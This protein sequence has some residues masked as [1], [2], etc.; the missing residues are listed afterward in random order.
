MRALKFFIFLMIFFGTI[1]S[2]NA[3]SSCNYY[4]N[5]VEFITTQYLTHN[6][7]L[8]FNA[9][10][11]TGNTTPDFKISSSYYFPVYISWSCKFP[12]D[13]QSDFYVKFK[14]YDKYGNCTVENMWTDDIG[15]AGVIIDNRTGKQIGGW[16]YY[17]YSNYDTIFVATYNEY[18]INTTLYYLNTFGWPLTASYCAVTGWG[19]CVNVYPSP[20]MTANPSVPLIENFIW[21]WGKAIPEYWGTVLGAYGKY[22]PSNTV[23]CTFTMR[24]IIIYSLNQ[25]NITYNRD[26]NLVN[27]SF[28]PNFDGYIRINNGQLNFTYN[29]GKNVPFSIIIPFINYTFNLYDINNNLVFSYDLRQF[30]S[31]SCLGQ[32]DTGMYPV[33]LMDAAGHYILNF[34]IIYT[35][36]TF[37]SDTNGVINMPRITNATITVIPFYRPDLQFN[38]TVTTG[39]GTVYITAP[40]YVYTIKIKARYV[41]ITGGE[42]PVVFNYVFSGEEYADKVNLS[43]PGIAVGGTAYDNV[44]VQVLAGNYELTLKTTLSFIGFVDLITRQINYNLSLFDD[45]YY[46]EI[47]WYTGLSGDS[48]NQTGANMPILSI[49]VVDQ[50]SKPVAN[51]YIYL[52]DTND[53]VLGIKPTDQNGNAI[54]YV[55]TGQ[56]YTISVYYNNV[57]KA[58]KT[59][60]YPPDQ[61]AVQVNFQ[62][63]ISTAEAQ[64]NIPANLTQE[65]VQSQI[66]NI[67]TVI[68]TNY[69]VWAFVF[70]IVFAAYAARISGS[71]EIGILTAVICIG[72]FTFIVPWLP[73]Q[74]IALIGVLAGVLLGLKVVRGR[75]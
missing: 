20:G 68:L 45:N 42:L 23:P 61:L 16:S 33:R 11:G 38:T 69:A 54:F 3:Q 29:F 41:P 26:S 24:Y 30:S 28:I 17:K 64:Q 46:R 36:Q 10:A 13:A 53:A 66:S 14:T 75:E 48:I 65:Q 59:V 50:N 72:V 51:A 2:V 37:L 19:V 44:T 52:N 40:Y 49:T 4:Q 21:R 6:Y 5:K 39:T 47:N 43:S 15:F 35:N 58:T 8:T 70:I 73:V 56:N 9:A 62:I 57:F 1:S 27:I 25:F 60:Y 74:I 34:K 18:P 12:S 55:Q 32:P 63:Y 71:P 7:N 67:L 22:K 31:L